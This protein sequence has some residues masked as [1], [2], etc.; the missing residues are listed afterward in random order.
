[1]RIYMHR[2]VKGELCGKMNFTYVR[3]WA[4]EWLCESLSCQFSFT[5]EKIDLEETSTALPDDEMGS[6]VS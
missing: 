1:M 6:Q 2:C 3:I 4:G 5:G